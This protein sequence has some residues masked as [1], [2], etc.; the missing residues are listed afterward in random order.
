VVVYVLAPYFTLCTVPFT[1]L[2]NKNVIRV[3]GQL[4]ENATAFGQ[5]ALV[6]ISRDNG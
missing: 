4:N 2:A 3:A 6:R 5:K 1:P